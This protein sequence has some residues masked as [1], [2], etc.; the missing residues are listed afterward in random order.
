MPKGYWIPHLDVS[1]PEGFEAYRQTA[2]A[3]YRKFGSRLL[4]RAGRR[5]VLE[6]RFRSRNV[7]REFNSFEEALGYYRGPEYSAAHELREPHAV[8]DF[9]IVEGYDGPQPEQTGTPPAAPLKGYWIAHVD[10][11]DPEGYKAYQ[12]ANA[13]AF[14]KFGAKF[15]VRGGRSEVVEGHARA[16]CVVIEFPSYEAALACYRSPDYQAA[17]VLREGKGEIDLLVIEGYGGGK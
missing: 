4:A 13:K 5:E 14:G 16:R 6:G 15:L 8:C 9:L 11:S 10:V 12:A 2:D 7:L 1:N 3:G 17:R